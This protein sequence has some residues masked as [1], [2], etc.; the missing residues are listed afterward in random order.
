MF[1]F[2]ARLSSS[3]I[4]PFVWI[5][6]LLLFSFIFKKRKKLKAILI[7]VSVVLL[8]FFSNTYIFSKIS[9]VFKEKLVYYKDLKHYKLGIVLCGMASY[10]NDY[11]RV[12][13]HAATDRLMQAIDLYNRKYIDKIFLSGGSGSLE[14]QDDK[15]AD[16][17][18]KYLLTLGIP[19]KDILK[20]NKSKNTHENALYT[21]SFIRKN[22]ISGNFLLISSSSHIKRAKLCFDK[23]GINVDI[24]PT[25]YEDTYPSSYRKLLTPSVKVLFKWDEFMHEILGLL[26]YKIA[27]YI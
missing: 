21:V 1:F 12:N 2:L 22:Q 13:F 24:Y 25:N 10:D 5:I 17:I 23:L 3:L 4:S 8:L 26:S 6:T 18:E 27:G 16:I 19:Q 9:S 15:E 20:E 11:K 14:N 7:N